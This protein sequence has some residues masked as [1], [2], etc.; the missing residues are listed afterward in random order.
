MHEGAAATAS[1]AAVDVDARPVP[2]AQRAADPAGTQ[3]QRAPVLPPPHD[4][5]RAR[6]EVTGP[7]GRSAIITARRRSWPTVVAA[8]LIG[9]V[10]G[11]AAAFGYSALRPEAYSAHSLVLVE[12]TGTPDSAVPIATV[13]AQ[14]ATS[15]AVFDPI[16]ADLGLD[17][18]DLREAVTVT[19]S[20]RAPLITV[21]AASQDGE[22]SADWAN[23]VAEALVERSSEAPVNGFDLRTVTPAV[24]PQTPDATYV[25][26][27]AVG[28]PVVGALLGL[29]TGRWLLR[30]RRA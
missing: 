9:A 20:D 27:V 19:S 14:V 4:P 13:W 2:A 6:S 29:M 3:P 8:A 25:T 21:T 15:E 5:G 12:T 17:S 23:A 11:A 1:G 28:A 30:R 10:L 16:A 7:G 18:E 26:S 24:P 22:R